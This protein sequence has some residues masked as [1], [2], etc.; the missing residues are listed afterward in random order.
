MK[1]SPHGQYPTT[2]AGII[3]PLEWVYMTT[4]PGVY[5]VLLGRAGTGRRIIGHQGGSTHLLVPSPAIAFATTSWP[6]LEPQP[7]PEPEPEHAPE[8][9]HQ[10]EHKR[11][12]H[13]QMV[14]I[15]IILDQIFARRVLEPVVLGPCPFDLYLVCH[16]LIETIHLHQLE[17]TWDQMWGS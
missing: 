3:F 11:L 4:S 12:D 1:P 13:Q 9:E 10:H 8:H 6:E 7:E 15:Y 17:P 2:V 16:E 5:M 14:T